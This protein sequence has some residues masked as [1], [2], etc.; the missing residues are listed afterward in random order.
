MTAMNVDDSLFQIGFVCASKAALLGTVSDTDADAHAYADTPSTLYK[1]SMSTLQV[2]PH[3]PEP[4]V[5]GGG[6]GEGCEAAEVRLF[7]LFSGH[8]CKRRTY[9]PGPGGT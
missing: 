9:S 5:A 2:H 7:H 8:G 6:G 4:A 1:W 3:R